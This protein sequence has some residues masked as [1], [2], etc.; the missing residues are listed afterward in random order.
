MNLSKLSL[1][2]SVLAVVL[3]VVVFTRP[4]QVVREV[5]T[6]YLGSSQT[7]SFLKEFQQSFVVGGRIASSTTGTTGTLTASQLENINMFDYTLNV[8][9]VTLTLPASSTFSYIRNPGDT[10]VVYVR[11][12]TT[13]AAMDITFAAGTGLN[14]KKASSTAVLVGN[15]DGGNTARLTF[16]R[17][18]DS[19][20]DVILEQFL[21]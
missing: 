9:D 20:I 10:K 13:T 3:S 11:N 21:D 6:E 5:V 16:I 17:Q 1:G 4:A 18:A 12:A 8:A 7:E 15:V 2:A 19:D 14:L